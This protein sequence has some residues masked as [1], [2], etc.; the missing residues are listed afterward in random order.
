M[1]RPDQVSL[2]NICGGTVEELFQRELKCVL[3]NISDPNTDAEANRQINLELAVMPFDDRRSA[4]VEFA[5]S[6]K[7]VPTDKMKGTMFVAHSGTNVFAVPHDPKQS[8]RID[9]LLPHAQALRRRNPR[10]RNDD[11]PRRRIPQFRGVN[12]DGNPVRKPCANPLRISGNR[13]ESVRYF[14]AFAD[15]V[16]SGVSLGGGAKFSQVLMFSSPLLLLKERLRERDIENRVREP[17][18]N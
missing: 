13:T 17:C 8:R 4:Q 11:Q 3:E 7:L 12:Y 2:S 10:P 16:V 6:S 14:R 18:G 9:V 15:S 1:E 5:C